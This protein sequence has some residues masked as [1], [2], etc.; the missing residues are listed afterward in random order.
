MARK[1]QEDP[2]YIIKKKEI[3]R[4]SQI[5]KN[6]VKLKHLQELVSMS[7]GVHAAFMLGMSQHFVGGSSY[8]CSQTV[9]TCYQQHPHCLMFVHIVCVR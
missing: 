1:L 2:L 6:P 8:I 9:F 4:R 3:E 7:L 5:F